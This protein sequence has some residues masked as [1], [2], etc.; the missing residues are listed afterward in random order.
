MLP[1]GR[2][3]PP[4]AARRWAKLALFPFDRF[5]TRYD[6]LRDAIAFFNRIV[7]AAEVE[8]DHADLAAV[9]GIDGAEVNGDRVLERESA[10]RPHLRLMTR[11]QFDGDASGNALR[12]ARREHHSLEG[13]EIETGVFIGAMRI[14]GQDGV[15]VQPL[16]SDS[17][18]YRMIN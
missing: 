4:R 14:A 5:V 18:A 7:G 15:R 1:P 3:E 11:R 9:A 10:A 13:A 8:H 2:S 6:Q 16:Y 17:H 12:D